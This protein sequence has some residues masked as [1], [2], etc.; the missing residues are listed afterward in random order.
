MRGGVA[1]IF[2]A[3]R[4]IVSAPS[5]VGLPCEELIA[6]NR[7]CGRFQNE[8][9][10]LTQ[11]GTKCPIGTRTLGNYFTAYLVRWGSC[12][13]SST[14]FGEEETISKNKEIINKPAMPAPININAP[15]YFLS[16]SLRVLLLCLARL[17][18]TNLI[19]G[20]RRLLTT[21]YACLMR[22][23][24]QRTRTDLGPGR[25]LGSQLDC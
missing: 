17:Y 1:R 7:G 12:E 13:C 11:R 20:W 19:G 5:P 15:L 24:D 9:R 4:L 23:T 14:R 22:N 6:K 8:L 16:A 18:P 3:H 10:E 25:G 2:P 21:D